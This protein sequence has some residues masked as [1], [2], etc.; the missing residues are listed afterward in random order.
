[1]CVRVCAEGDNDNNNN[2]ES[3]K[4]PASPATSK[5]GPKTPKPVL[6]CSN[7]GFN[8]G[9]VL[10]HKPSNIALMQCSD[11]DKLVSVRKFTTNGSGGPDDLFAYLHSNKLGESMKLEK[12]KMQWKE[13]DS[14]LTFKPELPHKSAVIVQR[15]AEK[16]QLQQ[17]PSQDSEDAANTTTNTQTQGGAAVDVSTYVTMSVVDRLATVRSVKPAAKPEGS[18]DASTNATEVKRSMHSTCSIIPGTFASNANK[19]TSKTGKQTIRPPQAADAQDAMNTSSASTTAANNTTT[20]IA[21]P[22]REINLMIERLHNEATDLKHSKEKLE[23]SF[24]SKDHKSGQELFKPKIPELKSRNAH[25]TTSSAHTD[26]AVRKN[27][28]EVILGKD[29]ALREHRKQLEQQAHAKLH[30]EMERNKAT[31]L[32][33][34]VQLLDQAKSRSIEE[35]FRLLLAST[36][37]WI[38]TNKHRWNESERAENISRMSSELMD[39]NQQT[40]D[41]SHVESTMM[42]PEI[43]SL[44]DHVLARQAEVV[45]RSKGRHTHTEYA[46]RQHNEHSHISISSHEDDDDDDNDDL[47]DNNVMMRP[48]GHTH[49]TRRDELDDIL[50]L[51]LD[52]HNQSNDNEHTRLGDDSEQREEEVMALDLTESEPVLASLTT[53]SP[54]NSSGNI[55]NPW[56][57]TNTDTNNANDING[58]GLSP[59]ARMSRANASRRTNSDNNLVPTEASTTANLGDDRVS[60]QGANIN[61]TTV[62]LLPHKQQQRHRD[63]N[64][65][66]DDEDADALNH[67]DRSNSIVSE[68]STSNTNLSMPSPPRHN[69]KRNS[70]SKQSQ[71][72]AQTQAN[73]TTVADTL[74]TRTNR[75]EVAT[76]GV[77]EDGYEDPEIIG[78]T[79]DEP[80]EGHDNE[81]VAVASMRVDFRKFKELVLYCL[82]K[83]HGTGKNYIYAPKKKP[84][85]AMETINKVLAQETFAPQLDPKSAK[86]G[87]KRISNRGELNL[88]THTHTHKHTHTNTHLLVE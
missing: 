2:K 71:S 19:P 36:N 87:R 77:D 79:L 52:R 73:N 40:L 58:D 67:T 50:D 44:L 20:T 10:A 47:D 88:H 29:E 41:L 74:H 31:A 61:T 76:L 6:I 84:D 25:T 56:E 32:K 33:K 23:R 83:R 49:A 59:R 13:L 60:T 70:T 22:R 63:N 75:P 21:K 42:I 48:Y 16:A 85:V 4:S 39:W 28:A 24:Y 53:V 86:L 1:V 66:N 38:L 55:A 78:A 26:T 18:G 3:K 7:C 27:I 34:S 81:N 17:Q 43:Q 65:R 46:N 54:R 72:Q 9:S 57:Q 45:G 69:L 82:K 12:L 64:G 37:P 5:K 8:Q 80:T 30:Q 51:Q 35:M 68:L 14:V 11:P 15:L 62:A